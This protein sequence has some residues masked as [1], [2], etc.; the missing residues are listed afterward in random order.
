[1]VTTLV[2]I[3]YIVSMGVYTVEQRKHHIR[4]IHILY[5]CCYPLLLATILDFIPNC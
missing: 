5:V 4:V 3:F 2:V 1:M